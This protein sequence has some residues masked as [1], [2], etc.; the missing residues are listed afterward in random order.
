MEVPPLSTK[1][2]DKKLKKYGHDHTCVIYKQLKQIDHIDDLLPMTLLYQQHYPIGHFVAIF[3]NGE[4]LNY[5][6]S[7]AHQIDALIQ[8]SHFDNPLGRSATG[9]D[10]THLCRLMYDFV[11][12][13]DVPIIWN[14]KKLQGS[15]SNT[16][17]YWTTVRHVYHNLTNDEFNEMFMKYPIQKRDEMIVKLYNK[18]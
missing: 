10:Y 13:F 12:R 17:G 7:T 15:Q 16:C 1:E 5:F 18:L 4:G 9:A 8:G 3:V 6:D 11:E 14:E 2:I